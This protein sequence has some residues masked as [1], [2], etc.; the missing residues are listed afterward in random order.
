MKAWPV[1]RYFEGA[2][3]VFFAAFALQAF[4]GARIVG[5]VTRAMTVTARGMGVSGLTGA[6]WYGY[7]FEPL[8]LGV[9]GLLVGLGLGRIADRFSQ[10]G[11]PHDPTP[12]SSPPPV[13]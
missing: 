11:D 12:A 13:A 5:S 8:L 4:F 7:V 6:S 1:R 9:V 3:V 2:G 10:A